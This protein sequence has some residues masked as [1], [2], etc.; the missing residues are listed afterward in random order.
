MI[1]AEPQA[2]STRK[3]PTMSGMFWFAYCQ[4][5]VVLPPSHDGSAAAVRV[6][7][8]DRSRQTVAELRGVGATRGC[9]R[10]PGTNP[11][12]WSG[13]NSPCRR[14]QKNDPVL[15]SREA[16]QLDE[17]ADSPKSGHR[18]WNR[19]RRCCRRQRRCPSSCCRGRR[20]VEVRAQGAVL[21][22]RAGVDRDARAGTPSLSFVA[23]NELSMSPDVISENEPPALK[24]DFGAH[25]A[26][27]LDAG[28]GARDVIETRTV[29][30]TNLHVLDRLGLKPLR[31]ARSSEPPAGATGP[32]RLR[33]WP[34]PLGLA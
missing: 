33:A 13:S 28:I 9:R 12:S 29:Q 26:T 32:G 6:F 11:R 30:A 16:G 27:D 8:R 24:F 18:G 1:W 34:C 20:N 14:S 31:K 23:V 3:L 21:G 19:Y 5:V 7:D 4:P 15:P 10:R 22:L 2:W 25:E 17:G